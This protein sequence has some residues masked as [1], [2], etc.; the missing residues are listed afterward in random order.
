M[1]AVVLGR[2]V[3]DRVDGALPVGALV[4]LVRGEP[5]G[6][7]VA[8]F[9]SVAA[10]VQDS[11]DDAAA[12]ELGDGDVAADAL[13]VRLAVVD[14]VAERVVVLV[15]VAD[16]EAETADVAVKVADSVPVVDAVTT[17][18]GCAV[19]DAQAVAAALAVAI[20]V[21]LV[22]DEDDAL[23]DTLGLLEFMVVPDTDE[24]A[25]GETVASGEMRDDLEN[26]GVAVDETVCDAPIVTEAVAEA[27]D[28]AVA[29]SERTAVEEAD[30][31][32]PAEPETIPVL[33]AELDAVAV[34]RGDVETREVAE[35]AAEPETATVPDTVVLDDADADA[36]NEAFG[37]CELATEAEMKWEPV[38]E[39]D[40]E[41]N[42]VSVA[43]DVG[44]AVADV[45]RDE[46]G[47][48]EADEFEV[49]D[50]C[51]VCE[52]TAEGVYG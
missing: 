51:A 12:V 40:T 52:P 27:L 9:T 30:S 50:V 47:E 8:L 44:E 20:V 29:E 32:T 35:V 18:E 21:V 23:D 3:A 42:E 39:V 48:P 37:D 41:I 7:Y 14:T 36:L 16:C 49:A 1:S 5:D 31:D 26:G 34:E 6:Q 25:K 22:V 24:V 13:V 15:T 17:A 33:S 10:V 43:I 11:D 28:E 19:S 38:G 45:V 46:V 2:A 4:P